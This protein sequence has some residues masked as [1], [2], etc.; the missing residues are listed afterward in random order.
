MLA[1]LGVVKDESANSRWTNDRRRDESGMMRLGSSFHLP[2]MF[3]RSALRY[4]TAIVSRQQQRR[5][6]RRPGALLG[7]K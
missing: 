3:P 1:Q 7:G 2:L 4:F 6:R 5:E